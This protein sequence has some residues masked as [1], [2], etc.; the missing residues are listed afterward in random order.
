MSFCASSA[1]FFALVLKRPIVLI[2][3][4][5]SPR[6]APPSSRVSG[7][8]EQRGRRLVHPG[9]GRLR[10]E[11][12]GDEQGERIDVV[13]LA[14]GLGIV[15]LEGGEDRL[16]L[17]L[18]QLLFARHR[19]FSVAAMRMRAAVRAPILPPRCHPADEGRV[20]LPTCSRSGFRRDDTVGAKGRQNRVASA[21]RRGLHSRH[22]E[23]ANIHPRFR[24]RNRPR[25]D[26]LSQRGRR[27]RDRP[28][29]LFAGARQDRPAADGH[30]PPLV[31]A[32]AQELC[33]GGG[34]RSCQAPAARQGERAR[35]DLRG[36]VSARPRGST[37]SS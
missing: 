31:R 30:V 15:A 24:L 21:A 18:A 1:T 33:P 22:H 27:R 13:E 26:R 7:R 4:G 23:T 36:R 12:D 19:R 35:H 28:A 10:G 6:R 25:R 14:L 34:A 2:S 5:S 3:R 20:A 16:D 9:V 32:V 17:V 8:L 11:D 37:I 29:A